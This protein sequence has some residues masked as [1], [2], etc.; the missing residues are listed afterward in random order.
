MIQAPALQF[1]CFCWSRLLT[2]LLVIRSLRDFVHQ[3]PASQVVPD[4]DRGT[5][6][7]RAKEAKLAAA[8]DAQRK[9]MD[10]EAAAAAAETPQ[11]VEERAADSTQ[12]EPP[13]STGKPPEAPTPG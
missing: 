1:P 9:A 5:L 10:E 3:R 7:V 2:G 8:A 12:G 4:S 11:A 6:E 13:L